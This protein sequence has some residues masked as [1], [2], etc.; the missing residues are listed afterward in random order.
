M[1][2]VHKLL[3]AAVFL[4]GLLAG[5]RT[6][7]QGGATGAISGLVLDTSGGAID[8]AEV[9]IARGAVTASRTHRG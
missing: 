3:M 2:S 6:Y 1:R 9:Q 8:G 5:V 7:G 4:I